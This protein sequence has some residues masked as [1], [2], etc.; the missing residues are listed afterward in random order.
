MGVSSCCG[1][2]KEREKEARVVLLEFPCVS[3]KRMSSLSGR[4]QETRDREGRRMKEWE[5]KKKARASLGAM[6][7]QGSKSSWVRLFRGSQ[8]QV[9]MRCIDVCPFKQPIGKIPLFK[10]LFQ[11]NWVIS[12][13]IGPLAY[14][15]W[16]DVN[17][18]YVSLIQFS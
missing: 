12:N 2:L 4:D 8:M 1:E 10:P 3:S 7:S 6:G 16:V 18:V 9:G 17:L 15:S 13:L 5:K 14:I 11:H